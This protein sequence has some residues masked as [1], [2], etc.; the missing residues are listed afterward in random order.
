MVMFDRYR[1]PKLGFGESPFSGG[2][3][4]NPMR[5]PDF[6]SLNPGFNPGI[7]NTFD[8]GALD[9]P[10]LRRSLWQAML[11]NLSGPFA[12]FAESL[13]EPTFNQFLGRHAQQVLT[14]QQ[15]LTWSEFLG[16]DFNFQREALKNPSLFSQSRYSS[17][18]RYMR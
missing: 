1:M 2:N 6:G 4:D 10:I 17:P 12:R 11:P 9:D 13:Y 16:R 14:G 8:E 15:P 18:V 7:L 5:N 3:R